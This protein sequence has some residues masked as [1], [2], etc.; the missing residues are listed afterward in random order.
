MGIKREEA[1][2]RPVDAITSSATVELIFLKDHYMN[3]CFDVSTSL[4]YPY[5]SAAL[6]V[7]N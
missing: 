1:L 7:L 2:E 3:H 6:V 4:W 5:K